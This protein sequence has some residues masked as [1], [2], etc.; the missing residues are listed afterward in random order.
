MWHSKRNNCTYLSFFSV[1]SFFPP[2][3]SVNAL[4]EALP[5]SA[6]SAQTSLIVSEIS[7]NSS[8]FLN[9]LRKLAFPFPKGADIVSQPDMA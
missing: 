9:K 7:F 1:S 3:I 6:W 4:T 2:Y 8:D 5:I